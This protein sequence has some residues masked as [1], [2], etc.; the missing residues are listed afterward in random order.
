MFWWHVMLLCHCN[1]FWTAKVRREVT[2]NRHRICSDFTLQCSCRV[3]WLC[4]FMVTWII[5][6][7]YI[8]LNI[9]M[10]DVWIHNVSD[11]IYTY[12]FF[13]MYTEAEGTSWICVTGHVQRKPS[14]QQLR[15]WPVVNYENAYECKRGKVSTHSSYPS[16]RKRGISSLL[17]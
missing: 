12:I 10:M 1:N 14:V 13:A 5:C 3:I 6:Y 17:C 7:L 8:N 2:L 15:K 9:C 16:V 11:I 4:I